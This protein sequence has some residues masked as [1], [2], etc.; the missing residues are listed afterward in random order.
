MIFTKQLTLDKPVIFE[1]NKERIIHVNTISLESADDSKEPI[2]IFCENK[3]KKETFKI[4]S[5]KK[6]SNDI[7]STTINFD[8]HSIKDKYEIKLKTKCKNVIINIIGFY[9][10]E[11][12]DQEK[13]QQGKTVMNKKEKKDENKKN[14]KKDDNKDRNKENKNKEKDVKVKEEK[15]K[16]KKDKK[17]KENIDKKDKDSKILK[18]DDS[19]NKVKE[20]NSEEESN[21]K[22]ESES[23]SDDN[24]EIEDNG[25]SVSLIELL[26]KKRKEEPQDL[27]IFFKLNI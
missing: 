9:E 6:N 25:P 13:E 1:S 18:K 11:E 4:C 15:Q 5:L 2:D 24:D 14:E 23:D 8:L 27:N 3:R 19:D 22:S 17:I 16:D 26:N 21:S 20:K 10:E 12:D 7:Y